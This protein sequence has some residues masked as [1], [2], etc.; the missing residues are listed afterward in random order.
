MTENEILNYAMTHGMLDLTTICKEIEMN[1]RQQF[2]SQHNNKIWQNSKGYY[3]TYVFDANCP[4][5]RRLIK[6][7][8]MAD[9]ED[10]IVQYYKGNSEQH[11]FVDCL[12]AWGKQKLEY[13]EIMKQTYDRYISD[14]Q[15]YIKDTELDKIPINKVSGAFLE[16]YIKRT[17]HDF[18][19]T[20]KR[21]NNLRGILSGTFRY[22]RKMGYT[23]FSFSTFADDLDLSKRVF[24]KKLWVDEEQVFSLD[25]I[26]LI[27]DYVMG[28]QY[29]IT[30]QAILFAFQTG[31]R[32]GELSTIKHSDII[33]NIMVVSRTEE[34]FKDENGHYVK[35]VRD[36]TKG[37]DGCRKVILTQKALEIYNSIDKV[38]EYV[39][40]NKGNR[41]KGSNISLKLYRMCKILGITPRSLHKIRKTYA[42]SLLNAG[43][44]EKIIEKQMGHTSISTTKNY[45]YYNNRK[46]EEISN[47]L[48]N[49]ISW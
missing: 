31:L 26:K 27:E 33:G 46:T 12:M 41:L 23:D 49:A 10:A 40:M 6:R 17:I 43:V 47:V 2:L 1:E 20:N 34:R 24:K 8:V 3:V 45:Y 16:D 15:R 35:R 13:G 36:N 38:G 29:N 18:E 7:K 44:D 42:T 11:Y 25:E 30:N 32:A 14:Y 5:Q 37:R 21:W 39:F 9:L 19:M 4:K 28:Q 48:S 22:A